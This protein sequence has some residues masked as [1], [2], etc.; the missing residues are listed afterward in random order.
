MLQGSD[1]LA[2]GRGSHAVG[3]GIEGGFTGS[4]AALFRRVAVRNWRGVLALA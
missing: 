4:G 3:V 1:R 2:P